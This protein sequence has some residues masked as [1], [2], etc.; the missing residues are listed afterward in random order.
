MTRPEGRRRAGGPRAPGGLQQRPFGQ[1]ERM[2]PPVEV[3]S[4]DQ[5]AAIHEAALTV[6]AE[7]G[8]RVL[9]AEAR[10]LFTAAGARATDEVVRFDPDLLTRC[11]STVPR[12]FTLEARNPAHNLKVGGGFCVYASVG[13]LPM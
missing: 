3:I 10:R 5:V 1:V 6:L 11:L 9:S 8:L 4:A 12:A 13:G 2:L 7:Q